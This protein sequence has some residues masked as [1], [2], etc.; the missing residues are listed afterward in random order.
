MRRI[1]SP[2][3][4]LLIGGLALLIGGCGNTLQ[5]KPIPHNLLENLIVAPFPV[6]WLGG[7]F[8][9]LAVTEAGE[10]ASGA[11][12]VQYGNCLA[13]GEGRCEPPLVLITSPD[14]SFLPGGESASSGAI[15]RGV[16]ALLNNSGRAISIPTGPVVVDIDAQ[17]RSLA[18]AAAREMVTIN[19]P[20]SPGQ[21]LPTRLPNTGYASK[22]LPFQLPSKVR[23]LG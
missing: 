2:L 18:L 21:P 11:F 13:G 17:Q 22:P 3:T 9:G 8:Q 15:L 16:P 1:L 12:T 14:N 5:T 23:P 19:Q 10:D 7:H 4:A 20:G 6:Y